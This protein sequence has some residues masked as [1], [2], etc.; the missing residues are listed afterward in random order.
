MPR[1]GKDK[2]EN[3]QSG[4]QSGQQ[5]QP[6]KQ[7]KSSTSKSGGQSS[8][9]Q[10]GHVPHKAKQTTHKAKQ[11]PYKAKQKPHKAKQSNLPTV[12]ES[13]T[14]NDSDSQEDIRF[15]M[16]Y[17]PVEHKVAHTL[18]LLK[19]EF[20]DLNLSEFELHARIMKYI[21]GREHLDPNKLDESDL[22]L[23][24]HKYMADIFVQRDRSDTVG[25]QNSKLE[26]QMYSH[27]VE[28]LHHDPKL[29]A[30]YIDQMDG[31]QNIR[32]KKDAKG[33][34]H[35][36]IDLQNPVDSEAALRELFI[37]AELSQKEF[38]TRLGKVQ[39]ML[40]KGR[41]KVTAHQSDIKGWDRAY[42]KQQNKYHDASLIK[43]LVRGTLVFNSVADLMLGRDY[44]YN[45]FTIY[46]T[47]NSIGQNTDT[48]YQDMKINV[49]LNTGHIGELQLHLQSMV[50]S[51]HHGGHG[52]YR[53]IRDF[54][55]GKT[56][57]FSDDPKKATDRL[58][59]VL[60][61][62][63]ANKQKAI[64]NHAQHSG[65]STKVG[66]LSTKTHDRKID[67][68]RWLI[69]SIDAGQTFNL[70]KEEGALLK[71]ISKDVY[72]SAGDKIDKEIMSN[73][74]LRKFFKG[75]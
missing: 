22:A 52:L 29:K 74:A 36:G 61:V 20:E 65:L 58:E 57:D 19:Q 39:N 33:K 26:Q 72:A 68:A 63:E 1:Q 16:K 43:D 9:H 70:T 15:P 40:S 13:A 73:S 25:T 67:F 18:N 7:Q 3:A 32:P 46:D 38:D 69:A 12:S 45:C 49:K 51:K 11:K 17:K 56:S 62:L 48:G 4:K 5:N 53:F 47:K 41:R 30:Q 75:Q 27:K 2:L 35:Q 54:D 37:Q 8:S 21:V 42:D 6:K 44:I 59:P 66:K 64:A 10:S 55:E 31:S 34:L 28:K 23:K 60:A 24:M 14:L 50:D 71:E